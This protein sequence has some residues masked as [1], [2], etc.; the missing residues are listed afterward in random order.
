VPTLPECSRMK[1]KSSS[2]EGREFRVMPPAG[3]SWP[4]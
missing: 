4:I 2:R 3:L 1:A